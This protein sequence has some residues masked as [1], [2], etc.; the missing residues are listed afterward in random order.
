MRVFAYE[1][2]CAAL[3]EEG[4]MSASLQVE[5]AAMLLAVV[6]DLARVPGVE[7]VTL[8]HRRARLPLIEHLCPV[9]HTDADEA[10]F[11][12]L[13]G[14]ADF[15]L[16]IAPEVHDLL[17]TRCC[18][19]EECGG[20]LLG[21]S[22]AAVRLTGDKLELCRHLRRR[23]IA[24]PP[25][26]PVV[27]EIPPRRLRIPVVYKPRFGAGSSATFL[28]RHVQEWERCRDIARAEGWYGES[29]VQPFLPG[30]AV[31]VA[32][33]VGPSQ[34]VALIPATQELSTDGRF[35]YRGGRLP[36]PAALAE[37][38]VLLAN[39]AL[40]AVPGLRGY[41]GVDLVL[42]AESGGS[43]DWVIEVNPRL[44]TSYLGL[45]ALARTNLA[46]AM[47]RAVMGMGIPRLE[48]SPGPVRF[49]PDGTV[50]RE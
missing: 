40:Q 8:L 23:K 10:A 26:W 14:E 16:V 18:W 11:R 29:L 15:T 31:S 20:R 37:R 4:Q 3:P 45:R 5:G 22:P 21:S 48:W 17:W 6:A 46:E 47:L 44:T 28:I 19:V 9:V 36:L 13:A 27:S 42:G 32:Y 41:I 43:R 39:R 38:A 25:C 50:E 12:D 2:A 24:T 30:Q 7:L 35:R 33:L 34:S 49:R 1:Y